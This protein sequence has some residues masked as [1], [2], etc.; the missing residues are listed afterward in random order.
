MI[1]PN[2]SQCST[3]HLA[4]QRTREKN[5]DMPIIQLDH[6]TKEYHLGQLQCIK[7]SALN[8]WVRSLGHP[9]QALASVPMAL[10]IKGT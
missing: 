10:S 6:V 3:A 9:S 7:Q 4:I 5:T 2:S 8:V 1:F